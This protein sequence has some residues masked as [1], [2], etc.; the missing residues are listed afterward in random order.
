MPLHSLQMKRTLRSTTAYNWQRRA[1]CDCVVQSPDQ[2]RPDHGLGADSGASKDGQART[3]PRTHARAAGRPRPGAAG[4]MYRYRAPPHR[5]VHVCMNLSPG[6]S[7]THSCAPRLLP[8]ETR[9]LLGRGVGGDIGVARA[10]GARPAGDTAH[11]L[12]LP[13]SARTP[14]AVRVA[15]L[16]IRRR[17]HCCLLPRCEGPGLRA[18]P[19]SSQAS[20]NPN[21]SHAVLAQASVSTQSCI[22]GAGAVRAWCPVGMQGRAGQVNLWCRAGVLGIGLLAP[23]LVLYIYNLVK[24]VSQQE[25]SDLHGQVQVHFLELEIPVTHTVKR[26]RRGLLQL[27]AYSMPVS[28]AV[29]ATCRLILAAHRARTPASSRT[30]HT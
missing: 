24:I 29:A 3:K 1:G 5:R 6:R 13:A 26:R 22:G 17:A 28:C 2:S 14:C 12:P 8:I 10:G 9:R 19:A 21:Y 27:Y 18:G 20:P 4:Y 15:A 23:T 16:L 30:I 7:I 11:A 25:I